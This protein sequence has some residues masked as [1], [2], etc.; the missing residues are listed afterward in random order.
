MHS[1]FNKA[2]LL[3]L[4]VL[5]FAACDDNTSDLGIYPET[6]G[7]TNS[8]DI[9]EVATQSLKM[10]SV[11]AN[12]STNYLGCINDPETGIDIS[13]DFAAQFYSLEG[14]QFPAKSLMVGEDAYGVTK[15]GIV[16]CDS[17]EVRL[18]FDSYYGDADTPMKLEVYELSSDSKRIMSEDSV[19]Y[20]DIDLTRFLPDGATPIVS[21]VF[22]PKDFNLETAALENSS[23]N[24]N[25]RIM[26]P[27]SFGQKIMDK[28]YENPDLNFADA[29]HF[30]RNV[31]PGFYFKTS[32]GKGTMIFV[33]VGT[34]N[35]YYRTGDVYYED[36]TYSAMTRFAATPEVIQSTH[37]DNEDMSS[38]LADNTCT[39]LK[40]PAGICTEMTLPIDQIFGGKHAVDSV[41]MATISLTRYNKDQNGHQ[42][43]TPK[44]LL[45]VRKK[46][47][48]R[49]FLEHRVADGRTSY[50][51]S[52]NSTDNT[53]T[54]TNIC[55]L[56]S[57]CKHE[58][59]EAMQKANK[60][61]KE[62]GLAAYTESEWDT[63]WQTQ[64]PDW[65]KV[66]IIPVVTSSNTSGIQ[67]SV[68]HD[69]AFNS[70]R[71]IGGNTKLKMQVIYSKYYQE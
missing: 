49:F 3:A 25:I 31:F 50:T 21:R 18:Y 36:S 68:T 35:L 66:V 46:D 38:L 61:R 62:A 34:I 37:F 30:I 7:I 52:F 24:Q 48:Y 71:L 44:E 2:A 5:G 10:D 20:T 41:S 57:Y 65:D 19:Y 32:G 59:L 17:C 1:L 22:T 28:Y 67:V 4:I 64:N 15:R 43:G 39:Y 14:Y 23:Y 11:V 40:T 26:L 16:K 69:L 53:Y 58:K 12:S 56:I 54:F 51:T 6:D 8:I 29:Y 33:S 70:I 9:Y 45:M 55:R 47:M 63:Q 60:E 13:A 42:L 27:A